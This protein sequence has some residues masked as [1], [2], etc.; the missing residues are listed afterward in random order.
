MSEEDKA[1]DALEM[2]YIRSLKSIG[3]V[4][5]HKSGWKVKE[6]KKERILVGRSDGSEGPD[7]R[8]V[9]SEGRNWLL[10]LGILFLLVSLSTSFFFSS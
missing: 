1:K 8:E 6:M 3:L 10:G 2:F 7:G 5:E 4:I 9:E